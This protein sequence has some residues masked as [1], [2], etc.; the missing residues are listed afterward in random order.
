MGV[1]GQ[2]VRLMSPA[3]SDILESYRSIFVARF[4][5]LSDLYATENRGWPPLSKT[6]LIPR[7][8]IVLVHTLIA[9]LEAVPPNSGTTFTVRLVRTLVPNISSFKYE[10]VP[11]N[12][13]T[14]L[15]NN[16]VKFVRTLVPVKSFCVTARS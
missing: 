9:T 13:G 6:V 3:A 8:I 12:N 5:S 15:A 11:P 1:T 4:A 10:A 7:V 16:T 14:A 2:Q